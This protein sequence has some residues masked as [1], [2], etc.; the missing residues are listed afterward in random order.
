[1]AS[2]INNQLPCR[3]S[4][5]GNGTSS[6]VLPTPAPLKESLNFKP[7]LRPLDTP[8]SVI[9]PTSYRQTALVQAI[10]GGVVEN[11]TGTPALVAAAIDQH[12]TNQGAP[13][14]LKIP[15]HIELSPGKI[16]PWSDPQA[17]ESISEA[18]SLGRVVKSTVQMI[19]KSNASSVDVGN[20]IKT[21]AELIKLLRSSP[22]SSG[23]FTLVYG[24]GKA[25][26]DIGLIGITPDNKYF[27]WIP[28]L[29]GRVYPSSFKGENGALEI[30]LQIP[31]S[32]GSQRKLVVNQAFE[33]KIGQ[34]HEKFTEREIAHLNQ[35]RP[36]SELLGQ[37]PNHEGICGGVTYVTEV[38]SD[39][40]ECPGVKLDSKAFA[41]RIA[42]NANQKGSFAY[43][44]SVICA[45]GAT[46]PTRSLRGLAELAVCFQTLIAQN[47][48]KGID[49]SVGADLLY[50][51]K[52]LL[53][54]LEM[55]PDKMVSL[56]IELHGVKHGFHG[57]LLKQGRNGLE[58]F[59]PNFH[60]QGG[61]PAE[62][63]QTERLTKGDGLS[64]PGPVLLKYR[65][66]NGETV[67]ATVNATMRG[68]HHEVP[69]I[70]PAAPPAEL[71]ASEPSPPLAP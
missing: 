41:A 57:V 43:P 6:A 35:S 31:G 11:K 56:H 30:S 18:Y 45:D 26:A 1:M 40:K 46:V 61:L 66:R 55:D 33:L 5:G 4:S 54:R 50:S 21:E 3:S 19:T 7:E 22:A 65:T 28:S 8:E 49:A 44:E 24:E 60:Q 64:T 70:A 29:G 9:F 2:G 34:N 10:Y 37:I 51:A 38:L 69:I 16:V 53:A 52:G 36:W 14:T 13:G 39:G 58:V 20:A 42:E 47:S 15:K 32:D 48:K 23:V 68:K 25:S 67:W 12:L 27:C 59:D 17:L 62:L 63:L 71:G